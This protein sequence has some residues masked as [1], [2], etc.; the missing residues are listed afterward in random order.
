[1]TLDQL[2]AS[3]T[4]LPADLP[5]VF[6][7]DDGPIGAGYHVTELKLASILSIDC[8]ART[9]SWTEAVLQLLDG[10]GR[11][12]MTIG[13]FNSILARSLKEVDGLGA[14]PAFVE[15]GHGNAGMQIFRPGEPEAGG[16]AVT[17]RLKPVRAHCKPEQE[18]RQAKSANS[19]GAGSSNSC[20]A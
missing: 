9:S 1:M 12:H 7:T 14:S 13:K 17:L 5:L 20:C 19:I 10:E 11:G 8:G 2:L 15:F 18:A 6:A 3:T 16:E 4:S